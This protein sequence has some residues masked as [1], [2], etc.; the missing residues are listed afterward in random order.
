MNTTKF[1]DIVSD[2]RYER[3]FFVTDMSTTEIESSIKINPYMFS[4]IFQPRYI[5]NIYFDSYDLNN[6]YDNVEGSEK[7][8]KIRIRWYGDLFGY[9]SNPTLE[10][11]VKNGILGKKISCKL[12]SFTFNS[13][14]TNDIFKE[15]IEN[16]N[17]S[18]LCR[19][20]LSDKVPTLLN[21]YERKYYISENKKFRIT[22][23][24]NQSFYQ[25]GPRNNLFLNKIDDNSNTIIELKYSIENDISANKITNYFPFR[26]TKSSKYVTGIEKVY[27]N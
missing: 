7:R 18:N 17:I 27:I 14:F 21:R 24:K 5:N 4:N 25:I 2:N 13:K 26:L 8:I 15:I 16:S 11:K 23:D 12:P 10:F 22:I 9:I 1:N 6:Y 20:K 19:I 3:K